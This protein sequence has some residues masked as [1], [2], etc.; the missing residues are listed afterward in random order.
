MRVMMFAL[1]CIAHPVMAQQILVPPYLQPGNAPTLS[2]EGKVVIWQTDSVAA[3]YLV[4]FTSGE[5]FTSTSKVMKSKVVATKLVLNRKTTWLY[6]AT[7]PKLSFDQHYTYRV[8]KNGNAIASHTFRTRTRKNET[9]FIAFGD[10]GARTAQQAKIS[11]LVH[12]QQ[13]EF[14]LVTG[15]IVY[16]YGTEREYR[17]N[18]FPYYTT[19]MADS[20]K[21]APLMSSIPFYMLVGNHDIYSADFAEYPDGLAYFYYNDLP[22]NAPVTGTPLKAEGPNERVNEFIKNAR[23]RFPGM[24]NF[25]FDHGNVH[26]A[27]LDANIYVNPLD[28]TLIQWLTQDLNKSKADWKIVAYHHPGFNSS[29][30]HYDYQQMRLLSPVLEQLG[31]D[32]VLTGHVHNYQRTYPLKFA[33]KKNEDGTRY[34]LTPEGRVDGVFTLD[35]TFDGITQTKPKGIIYIVTGAG[36]AGLYDKEMSAKPFMW[37]HEPKENWVPFTVKMISDIHSYTLIE[38]R[39]KELKL[40]QINLRNEVIDSIRVTK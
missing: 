19:E 29:K 4:E 21:G 34:V 37:K 22:L 9:R 20:T 25:S 2:K 7:L 10:C 27:C 5:S 17:R 15:D 30:A 1:S 6:K 33:P 32:L 39:A 36:G 12:Q 35:E 24:T 3:A 40:K 38:T 28:P 8:S 14:V 16:S 11:W 31:V 26:I 13:P 23:P 18:F